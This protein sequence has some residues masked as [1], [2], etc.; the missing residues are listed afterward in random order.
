MFLFVVHCVMLHW[1]LLCCCC[2]VCVFSLHVL[3]RFGLLFCVQFYGLLLRSVLLWLNVSFLFNM[4]VCFVCDLLREVVCF[5]CVCVSCLL[6]VL[7]V[8]V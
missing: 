6:F 3:V 4:L 2:C 7:C 8:C 1:L 5:V